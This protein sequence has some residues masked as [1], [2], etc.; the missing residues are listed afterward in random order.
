MC[1]IYCLSRLSS[2]FYF[3][4]FFRSA[5]IKASFFFSPLFPCHEQ[6][7]YTFPFPLSFGPDMIKATTFCLFYG[8]PHIFLPLLLET[9]TGWGGESWI[10]TFFSMY[11]PSCLFETFVRPEKY[12]L[13][14]AGLLANHLFNFNFILLNDALT[15]T[16]ERAACFAGLYRR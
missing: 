7:T 12:W 3:L 11:R 1:I 9:Y 8:Q 4:F 13:V 15:S 2:T 5:Y 10:K 6:F 16:A 14:W